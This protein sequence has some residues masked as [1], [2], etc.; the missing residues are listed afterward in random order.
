M[1][2]NRQSRNKEKWVEIE[3][4]RNKYEVDVNLYYDFKNKLEEDINFTIPE[5][6]EEK[7]KIFYKLDIQN[8]LNWETFSLIY[9][10][11]DFHGNY[12]NVFDIANEFETK[13]LT[14]I[15]SDT[16]SENDIEN[17]NSSSDFSNSD[18][19][20]EIVQAL[21]SSDEDSFRPD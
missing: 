3:E 5:L 12:S 17:N 10:E 9:K 7:Y 4:S 14:D 15:D 1:G 19:V 21:N 11:Q 13:F 6:F 8:N 2:R 20:I 16:E 18:N